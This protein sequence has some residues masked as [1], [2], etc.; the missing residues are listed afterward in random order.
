MSQNVRKGEELE[1]EKLKVFLYQNDLL[2]SKDSDIQISQ[3]AN[4]FSNLTYQIES[5][6][7]SFVLR[8]PPFGAIKRGHDMG[9]EYKVLSKLKAGFEKCPEVFVF[10]DKKEVMDAPFY[11]MEKIEGIILTAKEAK[12]L[13]IQIIK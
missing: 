7:K 9:R 1:E 10:S 11:I 6:N 5:E 12:K 8:R 2:P 13:N 4:G 3:F